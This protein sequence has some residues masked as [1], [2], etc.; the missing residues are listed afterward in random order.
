MSTI[1]L[2]YAICP[3]CGAP[4]ISTMAWPKYEFYCLECGG[5]YG[6]LQ[7]RSVE[8]TLELS[9]RYNRLKYEWDKCAGPKLRIVNGWFADCEKC[10]PHDEYHSAHAT[11]SEHQAEQAALAWL[12]MRAKEML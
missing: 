8:S 2:R 6:F 5:H 10:K 11:K 4:L 1:R 7:P 12:K 9:E 3:S